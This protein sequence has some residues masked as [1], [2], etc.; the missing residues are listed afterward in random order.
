MKMLIYVGD[1]VTDLP[2]IYLG[3]LIARDLEA[4][5]TLLHIA[6]KKRKKKV[7]VK[8]GESLLEQAKEKL[9]GIQVTTRIRRGH[10]A[11][12]ILEEVEENQHDMVVITSSRIGGYPRDVSINR[13]ILPKMPCCVV[14][15]KNPKKEI[16]RIL[17]LTG[18]LHISE[19]MVK[20]GAV[21]ASAAQAK[22]TLL[23][24]TANV[25]SMYTG[26]GTI[27]ETLEELLKT[28]TPFAQ[29]LLRCANILDEHNVPSNLK[30]KHGEPVY[31][32]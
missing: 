31:E 11:E 23:H 17:M 24:V 26:L 9:E 16:K 8:D 3:G 29:H 21:L 5:V 14:I 27:E 19:A 22:M 30:L 15:A 7:E 10:V 13:E 2:G 12:K 28:N 32:I 1:L 6:P 18:G 4:E 25:P 20:I